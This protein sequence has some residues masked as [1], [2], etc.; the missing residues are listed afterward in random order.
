[1]SPFRS[2]SWRLQFWYGLL[3]AA[4]ITALGVA[5][6][7]L[8]K[9]RLDRALDDELHQRVN[10]LIRSLHGPPPPPEDFAPPD[11]DRLPRDFAEGPDAATFGVQADGRNFYYVI[12]L[13]NGPRETR[14]PTAPAGI[15]RPVVRAGQEGLRT[16]GEWREAYFMPQPQDYVLVGSSTVPNETA[17][18]RFAGILAAIGAAVLTLGLLGGSWL[19][20]RA[21]RPIGEISAA[22]AKIAQGDLSQRIGLDQTAGELGALAGV[23][24]ESFARLEAAFARQARFTGDAAHELRTPVTVILTH[25]QNGLAAEGATEAHREA[26]A[27]CQ[28]AAQRMRGLIESLLQLARLDSGEKPMAR[29]R[30]DLADVARGCVEF[31]R[32][33]AAESSVGLHVEL[34]PA[35]CV[36]DPRRM[37]QLVTNL[38]VNAIHYNRPGSEVR[39]T[40]RR[41]GAQAIVIVTDTG[42]GIAEEHL[43]H[44]FD[45]F[46]RVDPAR[47]AAAGKAGLGLA[48]VKAV[49][50][51]HAGTIHV[52]SVPGQGTV[53]TVRFPAA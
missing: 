10:R 44:L 27:A 37:D 19:V 24:N 43:P 30:F 26:F 51:A 13:F 39:L 32:P 50:E 49:V 20:H 28:R 38:L 29:T 6:F 18:R 12:W 36:G 16:R 25:A 5:A 52:A 2:I 48:I 31:V 23:L 14:S 42:I 45:R 53:F 17:L 46:Y 22:A 8:E 11:G 40:T 9:T 4:V 7:R 47:T 34:G 3:L 35:E 41:E 21:L 1:M 15:P 33:L